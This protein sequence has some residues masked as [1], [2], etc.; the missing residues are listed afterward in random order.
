VSVFGI[1]AITSFVLSMTGA[2]LLAVL[3][4][5]LR[6][7]GDSTNKQEW[8]RRMLAGGGLSYLTGLLLPFVFLSAANAAILSISGVILGLL[9]A[10]LVVLGRLRRVLAVLCFGLAGVTIGLVPHLARGWLYVIALLVSG[11]VMLTVLS[12]A[13]DKYLERERHRRSSLPRI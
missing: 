6:I 2:G 5:S 12:G 7:Q 3:A 13:V 11:G 4:I 10:V 1:V 8:N 9:V